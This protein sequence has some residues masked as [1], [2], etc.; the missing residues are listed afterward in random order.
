MNSCPRLKIDWNFIKELEGFKSK[1]YVPKDDDGPIKSGV[2]IGAGFDI[3]QHSRRELEAYKFSDNLTCSLMYFIN[4][5]GIKAENLLEKHGLELG[6]ELLDELVQKVN[7]KHANQIEDEYNSASKSLPFFML[8]G[9]KQT[10]IMSVG[11]QYGSLKRRC[12]KFF[13]LVT[14][15]E[16]LSAVHELQDFGDAYPTRRNKEAT[17]LLSSI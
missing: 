16:W 4:V 12:P 9:P 6:E 2:T 15:H 17:L 10:V 3:G 8:D 5:T 13:K 14:N 1:G 11:F 7:L